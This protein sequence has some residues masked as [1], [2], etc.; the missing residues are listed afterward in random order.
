M[1]AVFFFLIVAGILTAAVTGR[2]NTITVDAVTSASQGVKQVFALVGILTFWLGIAKV[3]EKSGLIKLFTGILQPAVGWLFPSIPK[4][5]PALGAILM[6]LSAN[7]FG[8]GSA[9]TPFGLKAMEQLQKLN[10]SEKASEAM[11][12][13]LAINSTSITLIPSTIIAIRINAGSSNPMEIIGTMLFASTI[14][15]VVAVSADWV[16][17]TYLKRGKNNVL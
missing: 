10:R 15:T 1:N 16:C 14:S 2:I 8:F 5:H 3:A 9:A 4:G 13:F 7:I 11:C 12:T 6:N 17:R